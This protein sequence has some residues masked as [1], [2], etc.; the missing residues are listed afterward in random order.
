M[1]HSVRKR[2]ALAKSITPIFKR[3]ELDGERVKPY[4]GDMTGATPAPVLAAFFV[5]LR[6]GGRRFS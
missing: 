3:D 4:V 1:A 2:S 6:F 5:G